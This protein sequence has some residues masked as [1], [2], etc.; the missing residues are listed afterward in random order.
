MPK[1]PRDPFDVSLNEE[2]RSA[3]GTWLCEQLQ[4]GQNAK[5]AQDAE[6]DYWW[7][8][9]EQAKTRTTPPW[10]GAADLTS[11]IPNEKTN[12]LHARIMRTVWTEPVWTVEGWGEAADKAPFV[13]EF[14][15]W[16]A[17]E[18]RLQSIVD[19][20]ILQAL[21]EPRGLL[22]VSEGSE[23][24]TSRKTILAAMETDPVT[25]G[26]IHDLDGPVLKRDPT[27]G[28]YVPAGEQEMA[29][30]TVIDSTERIRTGPVYR[31]LPY[32]DSVILPGHAR[33]Q[34]EVWGYGKRTWRRYEE[35]VLR[36]KEGVYDKAAIEK[37]SGAGDKET[38]AHLQRANHS[39]D[40]NDTTHAPKELWELLVLVDLQQLFASLGKGKVKTALQGERWYLTTVHVPTQQLL[41]VQHDDLERSRFIHVILFP[42]VDRVTEGYSFVGHQLITT[43]EEHTAWRNLAADRA[44]LSLNSPIKR[45]QGA[46]WDPFEQPFGPGAVIDVRDPREIEPLVIPD[47]S[48]PALAHI[49]MME[50][51]AERLAGINDIA[52]GQV[53]AETRTLGEVQMA[54]E[55][56]FVRMDLIVRRFQEAMEDLAQIRHAIW[57]RVLAEQEDGE[58]LPQSVVQ[59]LEGRGVSIDQYMPDG[60]VTATLLEGAFKFKPHG[61]V[62][63]ADPARRRQ[64]FTQALQM[65]PG[66]MQMFPLPGSNP[67][68]MARAMWREFLALYHI[69]GKQAFLGSPAQDLDMTM[70]A[71]VM[72]LINSLPQPGGVPGAP[73]PGGPMPP[74]GAPPPGAPV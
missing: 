23:K 15:Q 45:Q 71:Q 70:K 73:P 66:M 26:P 46:L 64:D 29:V 48:Q 18:E 17:E 20:L 57:K 2:Q 42:R 44:K 22:E 59:N 67:I 36:A 9:Y 8:L 68:L 3:L 11:Y 34:A 12:A 54:T 47:L 63:T 39:L 32:R 1:K 30:E 62:Q 4:F 53:A 41:R 13:E 21:V 19:K 40:G 50:R 38:E 69:E 35:L 5:S 27:T 33:D 28:D 49:Q 72:G 16:K 56:S 51:T 37:M 65:L 43:T 25:G 10:E 52:S 6:V 58:E 7:S 24:R 61:S 31:L 55:Q 60:K 74:M 14:H